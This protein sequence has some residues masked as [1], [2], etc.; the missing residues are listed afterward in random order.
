MY[1][2]PVKVNCGECQSDVQLTIADLHVHMYELGGNGTYAFTCP[3]CAVYSIR[4]ATATTLRMLTNVG[5]AYSVGG[6]P[7]EMFE[8]HFEGPPIDHNEVLDFHILLEDDVR[9]AEIM[10]DLA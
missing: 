5:V 7:L 6:L 10:R 9:L 8:P 4:P 2:Y 1:S 3:L